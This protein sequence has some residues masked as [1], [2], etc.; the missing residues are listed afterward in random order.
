MKPRVTKLWTHSGG[1][2]RRRAI[3]HWGNRFLPGEL[4]WEIRKPAGTTQSEAASPVG[5]RPN[6]L[7]GWKKRVLERV[8]LSPG[9]QTSGHCFR[10]VSCRNHNF[11]RREGF[12]SIIVKSTWVWA[13]IS[14]AW[15]LAPAL[16]NSL[17]Q[18]FKLGF[19]MQ[20]ADKRPCQQIKIPW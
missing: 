12:Y 11:K 20:M 5:K 1:R 18:E 7:L 10:K 19:Q 3:S 9:E 2:T 8:R 14:L 17:S 15:T 6:F 16:F 13:R 4:P